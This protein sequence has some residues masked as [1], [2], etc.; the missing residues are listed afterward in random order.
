MMNS[1]TVFDLVMLV[2]MTTVLGF[3]LSN[4]RKK[5]D[6]SQPTRLPLLLE[7]GDM[8]DVINSIVTL[9]LNDYFIGRYM[10]ESKA[11]TDIN[12]TVNLV[13]RKTLM[14]L[15][16]TFKGEMFHYIDEEFL[17]KY[18]SRIARDQIVS[19]ISQEKQ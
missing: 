9:E 10:K 2:V 4:Y 12:E 16:P 13:T 6:L 15:S 18:I 3:L 11:V 1:L 14:H 19:H 8:L 7:F 5:K 17:I